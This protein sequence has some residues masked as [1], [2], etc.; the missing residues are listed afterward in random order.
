MGHALAEY[1]V[2]VHP[3]VPGRKLGELLVGPGAGRQVGVR[4]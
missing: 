3:I 4:A 1:D 2:P